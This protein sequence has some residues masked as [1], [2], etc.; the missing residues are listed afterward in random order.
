LARFPVLL[1]IKKEFLKIIRNKKGKGVK[2]SLR[3]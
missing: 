1:E 2:G 3:Q